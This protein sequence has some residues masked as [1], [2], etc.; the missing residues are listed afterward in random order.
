MS[1]QSSSSSMRSIRDN[2]SNFRS[3]SNRSFSGV[4]SAPEHIPRKFGKQHDHDRIKSH[5]HRGG[6]FGNDRN[7]RSDRGD[8]SDRSGGDRGDR[9]NR[10]GDRPRFNPNRSSGY[11]GGDRSSS[12]K[13]GDRSSSY[14]GGD[15]SSSYRGGDRSSSYKGGNRSS[16]YKGGD[17]PFKK[18]RRD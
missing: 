3:S 18:P 8:R 7:D 17:R 1:K 12:Y 13:G 15:R 2:K 4:K 9:N 11:K 16:S 14:R 5:H 10:G 6:R